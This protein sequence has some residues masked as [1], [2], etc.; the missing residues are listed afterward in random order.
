MKELREAM[1][2]NPDEFIGLISEMLD[3]FSLKDAAYLDSIDPLKLHN[4]FEYGSLT[5]FAGHSLGPV[6][7]PVLQEI[8]RIHKLQATQLHEG[9]F[10]E[11]REQRG[12]WFDCDIEE[13]AIKAMQ[14]MI[15]FSESC[16]FLYTQEGL[17]SNLGRLI[18]SFYRPTLTDWQS[19]KIQICHLGKEF[20]SDQAVIE[21]ILK[22]G[23]HTAKSFGVFTDYK[24]TPNPTSLT[25][26]ILPDEKGLYNEVEI[27]AFIKMH[28]EKIQILHLS[29]LVFST[30]Q[31]L[32]INR[33][34]TELKDVIA[35]HQIIVGL[36]LAHTVGNR[37]LNLQE[38]PVTYAVG[39]GYKHICGSAGSGFG[40]YVNKNTNLE[41]YPPIQGWKAAAS[42]KVFGLIDGFD[43]QIMMQKGAWAFRCSNP[44]PIALAPVKVYAKT[45]GQIGW[46]KLIAKSE[47]LTR[48][49]HALLQQ[50]LGDKI[51]WIT[52]DDPKRRGAM[53]VF[54]VKEISDVRQIETIL[55]QS[56][57]L[58]QFEIDV[59]PPNNIRVTAHYGYTQFTDIHKMVSRLTQV[60]NLLL[61]QKKAESFNLS[62]VKQGGK[63]GFFITSPVWEMRPLRVLKCKMGGELYPLDS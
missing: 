44:S 55:K 32:D 33:I 1:I 19:G 6:F 52:P 28:A 62:T 59:R 21:S 34:L 41:K 53:L 15:G 27:I 3:I 4:L 54:R 61:E 37:T 46:D 22:R 58:G 43:A 35:K 9:H 48:F 16:E 31:R 50:F 23:I 60:V 10:S 20:F 25:L 47:C 56:S 11:T 5:P 7:K 49:M 8:D 39:C 57:E 17:S 36:D 63:D 38:L 12:N 2:S 30:G 14:A 24:H 40:I 42:E 51:E 45:M 13:D 26:K 29:D 18:D